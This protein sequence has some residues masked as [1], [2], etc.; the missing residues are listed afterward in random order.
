MIINLISR[1]K[2]NLNSLSN[3]SHEGIY[4]AVKS[5]K[6]HEENNIIKTPFN[7]KFLEVRT[8]ETFFQ[9]GFWLTG[10]RRHRLMVN[11]GKRSV[12]LLF[13]R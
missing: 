10:R 6:G 12:G 2:I 1:V 3:F 11:P 7:K 5:T 8:H 9:K 13:H 4:N